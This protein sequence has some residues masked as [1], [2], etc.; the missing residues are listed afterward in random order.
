MFNLQNRTKTILLIAG[1]IIL[2][3]L[4]WYFRNIV[5]YIILSLILSFIGRPLMKIFNRFHFRKI[6][7]PKSVAAFITLVTLWFVF[8]SFFRFLVPL[9]VRE[10]ESFSSV[11]F[12]TIVNSL[13][14]PI[15]R[16]FSFFSRKPVEI[17][18]TTFLDLI[19]EQLNKRISFSDLSHLVN[20]IAATI[21]E[22]LIG[23]FAVTFI[24]YFFLKE[25]KM[26]REGVL[27]LVPTDMEAKVG[28][29]LTTIS[30]LLQR[31]FVGIVLEMFVIGTLSTLGLMIIG[32]GFSHA[33]IIGLFAALFNIIPYVGPWI[34]ATLGLLI[35]LALNVRM[36]FM[37]YTLPL[38]GWML[39]VF[40]VVKFM[41]DTLFQPLIYSS[42]VKAHPLEIFLVI[43]AAGSAAGIKGMI[44]AIPV[45]TILRVIAK[46]FFDNLKFVRR[47][48]ENID[49]FEKEGN[50]HSRHIM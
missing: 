2:I 38:L 39:L 11:D 26:F 35:G 25:E 4:F 12:G 19:S 17:T 16:F 30:H 9:L 48:T 49:K 34:G 15:S 43:L 6:R 22:L 47:I 5:T 33:V 18:D 36:D 41:D 42:S 46:E 3:F 7:I 23:F 28:K 29:I 8:I 13:K 24:T 27:L 21:G 45:Y 50:S 10:F 44:L 31:Y 32:L 1:G 14:E 20:F 40:A 37:Q